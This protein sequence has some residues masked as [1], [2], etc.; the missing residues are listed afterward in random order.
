MDA[1]RAA[2]SAKVPFLPL[3]WLEAIV[4]V[5]ALRYIVLPLARALVLPLVSGARAR[6]RAGEWAVVTGASDGIG[7]AYAEALVARGM[8]VLLI[9]RS[10]EKLEGVCAELRAGAGGATVDYHVAD[11]S[12]PG[13]YAGIGESA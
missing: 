12:A 10:K 13:V 3:S 11:F 2:L 1:L 6:A 5:E 9:A 4:L 8:H 7:K